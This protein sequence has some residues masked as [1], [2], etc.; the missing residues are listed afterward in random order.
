MENDTIA[1]ALETIQLKTVA[2]DA[3]SETGI[4]L[5]QEYDWDSIVHKFNNFSN[6]G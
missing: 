4:F 6:I 1:N 3:D 2:F 5:V